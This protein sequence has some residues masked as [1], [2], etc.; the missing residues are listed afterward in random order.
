MATKLWSWM[1][2][3]TDFA[4]SQGV[5]EF[6]WLETEE[7]YASAREEYD[8]EEYDS[9]ISWLGFFCPERE[10]ILINLYGLKLDSKWQFHRYGGPLLDV[11]DDP[12]AYFPSTNEE[13]AWDKLTFKTFCHELQHFIQCKHGRLGESL[14]LLESEAETVAINCLLTFKQCGHLDEVKRLF[15]A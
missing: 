2:E 10:V 8:R 3:L 5:R 15:V 14:A 13:D 7:A 9:P 1:S 11:E 4:K 6:I 12:C